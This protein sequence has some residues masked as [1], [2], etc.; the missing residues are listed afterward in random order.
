MATMDSSIS[1]ATST[2]EAPIPSN[3]GGSDSVALLIKLNG[4]NYLQWSHI[5]MMFICGRG[6]DGYLTG[7]MPWP[8][9][10]GSKLKG[11][12]IENNMVMSWLINSLNNDVG[13]NFILYQ[14]VQEI[15]EATRETC[16]DIKDT[17]KIFWNRRDPPW[18]TP[19]WFVC[20]SIFQ[21]SNSLLAET[22][23]VWN[24]QM[25]LPNGC[26]Q[27]QKDCWE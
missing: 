14:T 18:F 26:N 11:W 2:Q 8:T 4:Q 7:A 21:S 19:R 5:V 20:H 27:I 23:H 22:W 24:H 25:G 1:D 15:L 12:K 10:E 17:T 13:E 6:K 3:N 9:K 16:S